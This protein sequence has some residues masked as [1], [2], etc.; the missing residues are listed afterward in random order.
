MT[1]D[2]NVLVRAAVRPHGPARAVLVLSTQS[3]HVQVTSLEV[4]AEVQRALHYD[5]IQ[6][7]YGIPDE[8]IDQFIASLRGLADVVAL[9]S[10]IPAVVATD[11]DDDTVVATAVEGKADVLCTR[12]QHMYHPDVQAY[13]RRH[14]IRV[15]TDL[16]LL[17]ILRAPQP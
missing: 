12:D 10:T 11:P 3:P 6:K 13:C 9:P 2:A 7:K 17:Q 14:G 5:R 4:L 1:C 8:D 16:E 15:M